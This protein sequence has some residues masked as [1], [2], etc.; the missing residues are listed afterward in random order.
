LN[1]AA[2]LHIS[3]DELFNAGMLPINTV[4]APTIQGAVVTGM[5][6]IGVNTP[7][8]AAVAAATIGLD[9]L[10]HMPN[11]GMLTIGLLSMM[12]AAGVPVSIRFAGNTTRLLGA[13]PKLHCI[14]APM[15]TCIPMRL[16]LHQFFQKGGNSRLPRLAIR[17]R[18]GLK[19]TRLV[20]LAHRPR[21]FSLFER[22]DLL[23]LAIGVEALAVASSLPLR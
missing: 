21:G 20:V 5:H 4:G 8:A 10:L 1:Y 7:N 15:H 12:F 2:Q 22:S 11:G 6:G 3:L 13:T 14:I 16:P 17:P 9:G 19:I 23:Q 18:G